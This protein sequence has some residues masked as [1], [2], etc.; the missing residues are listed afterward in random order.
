LCTEVIF[1]EV[2]LVFL[3]LCRWPHLHLNHHLAFFCAPHYLSAFNNSTGLEG[4]IVAVF[5]RISKVCDYYWW[6]GDV[7]SFFLSWFS[8]FLILY[9]PPLCVKHDKYWYF[10]SWEYCIVSSISVSTMK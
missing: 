7:H 2:I 6:N 8:Q 4:Q 10:T 1:L 3:C 9:V 5:P